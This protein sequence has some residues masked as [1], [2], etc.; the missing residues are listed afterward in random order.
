MKWLDPKALLM[1]VL[2]VWLLIFAAYLLLLE[3]VITLIRYWYLVLLVTALVVAIWAI[4]GRIR[5]R[6]DRW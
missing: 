3:I 1:K 5:R 4:I 6:L 2:L